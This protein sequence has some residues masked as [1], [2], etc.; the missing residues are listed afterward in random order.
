MQGEWERKENVG[1]G[2][3][4]E[5]DTKTEDHFDDQS[6]YTNYLDYV[7]ERLNPWTL[8]VFRGKLWLY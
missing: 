7:H 2:G 6:S 5:G 1:N 8:F 3:G 4:E